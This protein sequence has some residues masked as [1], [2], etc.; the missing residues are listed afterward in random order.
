MPGAMQFVSIPA[1]TFMMGCSAGDGECHA[2]EKPAHRV[3]ITR[4]FEMGKYQVTQ[5]QYEA[6]TTVNPSYSQG[7]N[8]P[9][10]GVSWDDAQKFCEA[11][12]RKGDGYHYRLP[13]EAEWEY[14][15]RAGD[16]SCRYGPLVE[17]AWS[18]DNSGGKTHPVGEKKPNAFGLYDT[19][20]NVWE[21]VQDWHS[22]TYYSH[23]PE[24]DPQGPDSG[25]YRI[26]RGGSWR[27]L[28]RGQSR[29]SARYMLKPKVRS[30]VVGF[31]CVRELVS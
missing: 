3:S 5:A 15:A 14:A 24:S 20:G 28:V 8:L 31:R 6:V 11:V 13:T 19:L 12:N 27:G 7:P 25:E 22:I 29:V 18:R 30:I 17:V 1:G 21:W 16:T 26:S 9:V 4:P 2:D 10:E 23:S